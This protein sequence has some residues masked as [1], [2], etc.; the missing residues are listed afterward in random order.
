MKK[1]EVIPVV[2][3]GLTA[4]IYTDCE[5]FTITRVSP[6]GLTVWAK[7]DKAELSPDWKPEIVP[8]GFAGHCTN[9]Y[10]QTYTY[11]PQPEAEEV[12]FRLTKKGWHRKGYASVVLG[13]RRAFHDYNF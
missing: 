10:S 4:R 3:M 8:G 7:P 1:T 11:T 9:N 13:E 2:G 5:A 12:A 6:S